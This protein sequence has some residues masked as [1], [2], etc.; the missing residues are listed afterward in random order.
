VSVLHHLALG[1]RDPDNLAAFYRDVLELAEVTRHYDGEELRSVWLSLGTGVLMIERIPLDTPSQAPQGMAAGLFLLT[2]Q[3]AEH[4]R[5]A[6][7]AKLDAAGAAIEAQTS[8]TSYA[9][10]PEGNRVAI[11]FY[12]I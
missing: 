8:Y 2:I 11:S 3:I 7:V 5:E 12:P 10:D 6:W 4:D 9:R 1:A